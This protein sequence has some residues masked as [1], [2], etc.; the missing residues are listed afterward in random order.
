[1]SWRAKR[2][3]VAGQTPT[4]HALKIE[5]LSVDCQE[6]D[7]LEQQLLRILGELGL[8]AEVIKTG[9]RTAFAWYGLSHLPAIAIDGQLIFEGRAP[10]DAELCGAL[11]RFR[12]GLT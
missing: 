12:A 10:S 5:L 6:S 1:M 7:A 3:W 4:G 2:T 8:A 11:Q 9:D